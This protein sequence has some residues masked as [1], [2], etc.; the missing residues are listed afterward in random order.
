M[1][2]EHYVNNDNIQY[3]VWETIMD[4]VCYIG[5]MIFVTSFLY[6]GHFVFIN[7]IPVQL[8]NCSYHPHL[9]CHCM[10]LFI[11]Y[12]VR[13]ASGQTIPETAVGF[14]HKYFSTPTHACYH[15][16]AYLKHMLE[17]AMGT[18]SQDKSQHT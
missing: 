6:T 13:H 4:K 8:H 16:C 9:H 14:L 7:I 5:I 11:S 2:L 18:W 3:H 1:W 12:V 15:H 17:W 10:E